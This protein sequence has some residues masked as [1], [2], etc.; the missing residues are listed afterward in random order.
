MTNQE[1]D[2]LSEVLQKINELARKAAGGDYLYRGEPKD[3]PQVS[4]KLYRD[5]AK[6]SAESFDIAAVQKEILKETNRFIYQTD[7]FE[8]LTQL[9]H[10]GCA[11]N[12]IDFTTDYNIA[13][14]FACYSKPEE[15]GR[16]IIL[17]KSEHQSLLKEP[18]N[19]MNRVVAQKSV[20]VESPKGFVEPSETVVIPRH[21]KIAAMKYLDESHGVNAATVFNDI[22]GFIRYRAAHRSAYVEIYAGITFAQKGEY[23][24][25]IEHF[26]NAIGLNPQLPWAFNNRS[27][28]YW[29]QGNY[30][31]AIQDATRAIELG[32]NY[33][34]GYQ[35][36][37]VAYWHQGIYNRAIQ[38]FNKVLELDPSNTF[39]Y[40]NRGLSMLFTEEQGNAV[41]DMS[42]AQDL[43]LDIV[44]TFRDEFRSVAEF[45]KNY[46]I[47][48]PENI[49]AMLTPKQ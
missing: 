48:L 24:K 32:P 41:L 18:K 6:I 39:A 27:I 7:E 49:K 8:V 11:T 9:Q 10:F 19:P 31:R 34:H 44:S 21:L 1:Q 4:S 22:H 29:R 20:F 35:S 17:K 26:S 16:V 43:G 40:F 33:A 2:R 25:A 45:E 46:S 14:F 37:G 3:Y 36:R 42:H 15:D 38:D 47:Q 23:D 28:S 5:Y 13:L 30:N 12:L